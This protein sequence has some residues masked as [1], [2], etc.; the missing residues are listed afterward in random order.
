M[1][2]IRMVFGGGGGGGGSELCS[3]SGVGAFFDGS[4]F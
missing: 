1:C 3:S 4:A 2:K